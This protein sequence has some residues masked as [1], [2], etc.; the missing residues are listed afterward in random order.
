MTD[1]PKLWPM[2]AARLKVAGKRAIGYERIA[3]QQLSEIAA[4]NMMLETR[5]QLANTIVFEFLLAIGHYDVA[6][7]WHDLVAIEDTKADERNPT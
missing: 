6:R 4:N 2:K 3:L 7:A 5:T 1:A